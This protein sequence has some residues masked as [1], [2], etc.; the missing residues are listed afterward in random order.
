MKQTSRTVRRTYYVLT[1]GNTLAASLIWGINTIFLLDAGLTNFEAFAAN[2]CF[3]AGMVLFEIP[4]GVVADR[5]GRRASFLCGTLTLAATTGLYVLLWQLHSGFVWWAIVSALLGLGF[6][7]F[8]GATDAWLVDALT[9]TRFK[10]ELEGVFARGQVVIGAMTLGGSVA[11]GFLAQLTNLGVPYVVRTAILLAMFV[12]A[13]IMMHDLGFTPTRGGR[14]LVEMTKIVNRSVEHG[15]KVPAVRAIMLAGMFSGG[16]GIYVY[17]ALQPYLLNL[18]GNP[19]AYGIAGLVAALVAGAQIAGGL[20]TPWIR[21]AFKR[22]TSALLILEA[23]AVAMLALIGLIGNFWLVVVLIAF[24]GLVGFA[25]VPI[26]QAYLNGM[27]PSQERATILSF[28]SLINS[29]GGIVAQPLLGKS[30]DVWG[31]QVSYLLSAAGSA[32]ALPFIARARRL[33]SPAD[34]DTQPTSSSAKEIDA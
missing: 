7:F 2:A 10:G 8:S 33:N 14:P 4:T 30:A 15:L 17:Y 34:L 26:R 32:L 19:K 3:T 27:I 29:T 18:W 20:L 11:G 23:L 12:L 6:T 21:R 1:A 22:R 28:D 16:V 5:W 9:A 13:L 25:G 24:W 31:Y